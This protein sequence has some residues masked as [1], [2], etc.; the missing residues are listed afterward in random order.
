MRPLKPYLLA[1]GGFVAA[2]FSAIFPGAQPGARLPAAA[3]QP[4]LQATRSTPATVLAA[5]AEARAERKA[6]APLPEFPVS[7]RPRGESF[8]AAQPWSLLVAGGLQ[9]RERLIDQRLLLLVGVI[10]LRI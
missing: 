2:V 10:E 7:D 5:G 3:P 6:P 8:R 1:L 4:D 9:A